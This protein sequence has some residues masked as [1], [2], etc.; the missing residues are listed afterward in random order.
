MTK[1]LAIS[2]IHG[3][4]NEKQRQRNRDC[5]HLVRVAELADEKRIGHV[6]CDRY[7]LAYDSRNFQCHDRFQ[8]RCFFNQLPVA[9]LT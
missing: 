7:K 6:V 5:R 1:I 3:E 4:E 8:Y 2:D 9:I